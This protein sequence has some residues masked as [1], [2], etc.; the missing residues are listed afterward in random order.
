LAKYPSITE[1]MK[2]RFDIAATNLFNHP[3]YSPLGDGALNTSQSAQVGVLSG[4][5]GTS[6]LDLSGAR[7]FRASIRFEWYWSMQG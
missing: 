5:G 6:D 7:S 3:N 1:R 2:L 4:V